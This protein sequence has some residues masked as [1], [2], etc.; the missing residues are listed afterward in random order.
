MLDG[1]SPIPVF[2]GSAFLSVTDNGINFNKNVLLRMNKPEYVVL[3]LNREK[4]QL[5]IQECCKEN[6]NSVQFYK[7]STD[8]KYGVRFNNRD[9]ENT[10]AAMMNW[11]LKESNYRID[12]VYLENEHAM[13]FDL[14]RFRQ[15]AKKNLK[16]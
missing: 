10:I 12:G 4:K 13:L 11:N 3:L 5:A 7:P 14:N 6:T 8:I 16:K 2:T 9:I 15:F 1:F